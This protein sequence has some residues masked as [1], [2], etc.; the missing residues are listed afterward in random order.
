MLRRRSAGAVL[1]MVLAAMAI[2]PSAAAYHFYSEGWRHKHYRYPPVPSGYSQIVAVFG[3]PC[4]S[5]A[6]YNKTTWVARDNNYAYP[7][8]YH[9][10]LGGYGTHYGGKGRYDM[11]SN[12]NHDVRGHILNDHV[13]PYI[14]HGIYGY[15]C[16]RISGSS[17]WSTHAW[18]IAV[19]INSAYEHVGS[20]HKH[21]HSVPASV[22]NIWKAHGWI[23][24][25][26]FGDCMHFQYA[27]NY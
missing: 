25:V 11:S 23:H 10:K 19:D 2:A 20:A 12:L 13:W 6:R 26:T 9:Y 22:S 14:K 5:N 16:R 7:V 27:K 17:K 8:Y 4:N 15:A 24:G 21:C 1:A 3:Q 18:G